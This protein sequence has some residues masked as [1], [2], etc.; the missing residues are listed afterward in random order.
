MARFSYAVGFNYNNAVAINYA[1]SAV[2]HRATGCD[3][4]AGVTRAPLR[5]ECDGLYTDE[6]G[7]P[8]ITYHADCV[9]LIFY[10]PKR[11]NAAICHA[12]WRGITGHMAKNAIEA[13]CEIDSR[14]EDILAAVGPCISV[15][16]FEVGPEVC[17][18]F[19]QEYGADTI[20]KRDGSVYVDLPKACVMDMI[21]SGI[22]QANITVSDICTFE[23]DRLFFSHRRDQGKT[24]AFA[25]V[26]E[27]QER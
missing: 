6:A 9:P 14:P 24:G 26:I 3:I 16:H 5:D 1:H 8:M 20:E 15:R 23:T 10:D 19:D 13:L 12:G 25:A 22:A 7:L 17:E 2:L 11:R 21:Q 27:L 4:G 18:I